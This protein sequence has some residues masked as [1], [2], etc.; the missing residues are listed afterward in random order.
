M[1]H[2]VWVVLF[3]MFFAAFAQ[4]KLIIHVQSPWR[5]D[6]SKDGYFLHMLGGAGGGYNP[7][8]GETSSTRMTDEGDGWFSYTWN[9]NASDFQDWES[10]NIGIYPNTA[11]QNFNNNNGASWKV[12]GDMKIGQIFGTDVEVWLYTNTTD[13]TYEKSFVAPGSK[14]VWFK[15]PWGNKA[16]PQMIFGQDSILMRFAQD[17]KSMCGW[18]YGAVSPAVIKA[19]PGKAVHFIRYRTP[20]MALPS[21]GVIELGNALDAA[22]T[23]Y[24]DGTA[25]TLAPAHEMGALG[26]CFDSTRVL[27]IYHPWRTNSTF[28][29]SLV[30]ISIGNNILN[31]PVA[32]E[33]DGKNPYW[34]KYEF[35]AATV[36]STNW[37]SSMAQFNIYRRQNEWPQ[38]TFFKEGARPFASSLFPTGVYETWLYTTT[39]GNYELL[40]SPLEPK[41]IRLMSPWDNMS[42][43]MIVAED[44]IRMGPI[45]ASLLDTTQSDTCGWYQGTYYKHTEDWSV[46][47]RQSFG[48]EFY[49]LE[50]LMGE[51]GGFGTPISLDSMIALYDTVWV[52][53]YP[54]SSSAPRFKEVYPERLGI[55]PTMKISAMLLDWAGESYADAIDIDF[56][57][58]YGGNEYTTII[59]GAQEYKTCGGHVLG[60][61]E[62]YLSKDGLPVRVDS[63]L[64]PW[65][66]CSAGREVDKWFIPEVLATGPDGREY[67]NATC[68]DIDLKLDAE[69]FW[70][71]DVTESPNG[72]ND[73]TNPGFYP[74]DDFEYLDSAK[75]IKNPKFDWDVQGC[76]HNYSFSM[77]IT[78]QFKYI[79]GQYFEFRGDDDVWVFINNRLVVDIGGCHSPVE[80]AVDLDTLGL[81]EGVEY[82][83]H[84]FFSE[85]N[86]TGSNFKMRTSINL[87]TQKTYYSEE[88]KTADG[89]IMY[90]LKQLLV[91]ESL[92]CDVSSVSKVD[93]SDAQSIFVLAG[94]SLPPDGMTLDPG[95]NYG[96]ILINENMAGFTIDTTAI[97]R[98]R[99]LASGSYALICYLASDLSQYQIIPFT[100]PEYPLPD[101]GFVD[102]FNPTDS[103]VQLD[104]TGLTL[105][106]DVMGVD[107]KNDTLLAH[108]TYPDGKP[109]AV[110]VLYVGKPCGDCIVTLDL[111][112]ADS[113]SFLS[114]DGQQVTSI[115]TDSL[116]YAYFYV[117][118]ETAMENASF[119]ISSEGVSNDLVWTGIHFK[120][121]PVPFASRGKMYDVNGDGVV[122]SLAIPFSKPFDNAVPDTLAWSFGESGFHK[123]TDAVN[124]WPLV[125]DDSI[126]VL[127]DPNGLQK[128]LFTGIS[129][130]V[131]LGSL[132]YHYTYLDEDTGDSVKLDMSTSIEDHAGPVILSATIESVN[133]N[134]SL[135]TINLSEGT[136]ER[137]VNGGIAFEIFRDSTLLSDS[138]DVS[139]TSVSSKG[140]VFKV[141][142]SRAKTGVL[143]AVGDYVKM[144][145]GVIKDRSEN[146]AHVNNP[147]V[148]IVGEQRTEISAPGVVTIGSEEFVWPHQE[149]IVPIVVPSNKTVKDIVDSL[150]MPGLLLGFDIGELATTMI[151]NLPSTANRDSALGLIKI[152][153]EAYYYS[154]L[155]NYVNSYRGVIRCNDKTVFYNAADPAKSN[156]FDNPGNMFFEWNGRSEDGRLVG[157]GPYIAKMKV[158]VFS[159]KTK[160]GSS[161]DTYTIGIK[162]GK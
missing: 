59:Q 127:Y 103:F 22:D 98:S 133:E 105:R 106:G 137:N 112:S 136:S 161:E 118:G 3:F 24:I 42:P 56:G 20:Y 104:P 119:K 99:S 124:V 134:M 39:S 11:D 73:P 46:Q 15:S 28:K 152:N 61:V 102:I 54:L 7:Q 52:Y 148:R 64:F 19:N 96:G 156:C 37:A 50:G 132:L 74:L 86:A 2:N 38:V 100:V 142:Y 51:D 153:W 35:D 147:M 72:C 6:L 69:G 21:S 151:M 108:V 12:A 58:I 131:Y 27:H 17:D 115:T 113:I 16:L 26:E 78:A 109:L 93:T 66:Q 146:F 141:F 88:V 121:P 40:F 79:K 95:L 129:D 25:N 70:L 77:K 123:V 48:T 62:E 117:V 57:G 9:K 138:L 120:E 71:A 32:T 65:D 85:R 36:G 125:V 84:I 82:P 76:K 130:D 14:M 154:H 111:T 101:I 126:L 110:A 31:N 116:G 91:D 1:R 145:P 53:P 140:N 92:S 60:M 8:F 43:M 49:S 122:D 128:S 94:G 114:K 162:R 33:K 34:F 157:T 158:K 67:T 75:T 5:D 13:M 29:D 18:F 143:P 68:R 4:A 139:T 30:Y 160:A 80:G 41:T 63:T 10:F 55:C 149:S 23:I 87:Q 97:V 89:T 135:L 144:V 159:G 45:T 81:D 107:P 83:F 150:G 47:F 90:N 155:G 44:T